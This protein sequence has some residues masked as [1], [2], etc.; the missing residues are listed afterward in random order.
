ME[1]EGPWYQHCPITPEHGTLL[2][3]APVPVGSQQEDALSAPLGS[4]HLRPPGEAVGWL[5][6]FLAF[7]SFFC[8]FLFFF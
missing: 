6:F 8:F 4:A 2:H 3:G 7:L 5:W 1:A